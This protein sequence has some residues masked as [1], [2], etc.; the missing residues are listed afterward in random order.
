MRTEKPEIKVRRKRIQYILTWIALG[1]ILTGGTFQ[2]VYSWNGYFSGHPSVIVLVS[3]WVL[4]SASTIFLFL[5]AVKKA[6]RLLVDEARSLEASRRDP[7]REKSREKKRAEEHEEFDFA[8]T[9]RKLVRRIPDN[10]TLEEAGSI[11]LKNLAREI[12][13]MSGIFFVR[14]KDLF[15]PADSYALASPSGPG[16]FR[17]G[18]GLT[19]QAA[20]NRQVMVL[21]SLPDDYLKISSGLGGSP[22]TYLAF[23][24]LVQNDRVIAVLE[25]C[26]YRYDPHEIENMF[27]IFAREAI[28]KLP[29]EPVK[30]K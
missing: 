7:F 4:V 30:K 19:G 8:A 29:A 21:T 22:P 6:H 1:L 5:L 11:V 15:E 26:G 14:R 10:S 17:E 24:P 27:R 28:E 20:R 3:V 23:V 25:C 9:A 13:I 16:V 18:E 2:M 12:E